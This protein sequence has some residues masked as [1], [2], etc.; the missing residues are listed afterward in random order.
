MGPRFWGHDLNMTHAD[1]D[2]HGDS[3]RRMSKR[4]IG[5]LN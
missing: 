4:F 2:V 5:G 1:A 3:G